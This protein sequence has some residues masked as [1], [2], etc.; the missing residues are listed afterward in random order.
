M[1]G[2]R[3]MIAIRQI[4]DLWRRSSN[5]T[6]YVR[7][8]RGWAF[9]RE[10]KLARGGSGGIS[11]IPHSV[12]PMPAGANF[13]DFSKIRREVR[14][15]GIACFRQGLVPRLNGTMSLQFKPKIE[16]I[17]ELLLYLAH[18]RPNSDKYQA[19][20]FFY[21]ADREHLNR[22]GRPIT[23]EAYFALPFGP[24][25]STAMDLI[26]RD[27]FTMRE[28]GIESLPFRF[29]DVLR[30]GKTITYIRDPLREVDTNLFSKSDLHVF[31]EIIKKYGDKSFDD[32]F[33]ITHDHFAYKRAW[34]R[35]KPGT[36]RAPMRYE[37]MI[38]DADRRAEIIEDLESV[39]PFLE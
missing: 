27:H 30:D 20:K 10:A 28:A 12:I 29:E 38:E 24:V 33:N 26:E 15:I 25:A 34:S 17:L 14:F 23:Q 19:V 7:N 22:Y 37:D 16:K 21:L 31:D 5:I 36:R 4:A 2:A 1:N 8:V 13:L 35:R 18:V 11:L 39:A 9:S 6:K 3:V 32:L